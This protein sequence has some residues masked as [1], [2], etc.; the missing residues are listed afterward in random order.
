MSGAGSTPTVHAYDSE[1]AEAAGIASRLAR[2]AGHRRRVVRPRGAVPH[3]RAV[4]RVRGGALAR[5]DPVPGARGRSLPRS[6]RGARRARR[7]APRCLRRARRL[8]RRRARR[9][10]CRRVRTRHVRRAARHVHAVVRSGAS[11]ST[12]KEAPAPTTGSSAS[13]PRP[14]RGEAPD[15]GGDVVE[16]LTFHRAKGLEFHTVFVTGLERGLVPISHADTP[17][18]R[19]EER[20]L[21]YVAIDTR[22][23]GAAPLVRQ[24]ADA[25]PAGRQPGPQPVA[26]ADRGG[27]RDRGACAHARSA[28]QGRPGRSSRAAGRGAPRRGDRRRGR[29]RAPRRA[30]RVAPLARGV[31]QASRPT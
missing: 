29:R 24:A 11:T 8:V 27:A 2:R 21:L 25:R 23:A 31:R 22:R 20:R 17:A 12:S 1:D 30:G 10:R 7:A 3:E 18:E 26:R 13:S 6:P 14:S 5:R 15:A 28:R 9:P 4:G 19:A 16:L